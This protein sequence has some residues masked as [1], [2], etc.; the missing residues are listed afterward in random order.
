MDNLD[1]TFV[2]AQA[3]TVHVEHTD[4]PPHKGADI[5]LTVSLL[6]RIGLDESADHTVFSLLVETQTP[7][8]LIN[9]EA[10][11]IYRGTL[12]DGINSPQAW[13]AY[14]VQ[15]APVVREVLLRLQDAIIPLTVPGVLF[16]P[17]AEVFD[18]ILKDR[19]NQASKS[20]TSGS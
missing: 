19:F 18:E 14:R 2:Q 3:P 12:K 9:I 15:A 8:L 5:E 10:R 6:P 13:S 4:Q 16:V 17:P 20:E 1:L 11:A 7:E